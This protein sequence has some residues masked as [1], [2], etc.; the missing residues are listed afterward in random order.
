MDL[1]H[2]HIETSYMQECTRHSSA[3]DQQKFLPQLE[4]KQCDDGLVD[5]SSVRNVPST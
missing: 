3:G 2:Q 4:K 1:L 5:G